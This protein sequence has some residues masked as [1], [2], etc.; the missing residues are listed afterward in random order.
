MVQ[1]DVT[2]RE[3]G[4]SGKTHSVT[5]FDLKEAKKLIKM[6]DGAYGYKTKILMDCNIVDLG[7]I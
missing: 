1:Y 2:W 3:N 6:H 4:M 5:L 7:R